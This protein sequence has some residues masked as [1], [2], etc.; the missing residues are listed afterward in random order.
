MLDRLERL[1]GSAFMV[2]NTLSWADVCVF[3]RLTQLL[4]MNETLL[5]GKWPKLRNVYE[6]VAALNSVRT[7][8]DA[9]ADDYPRGNALPP[10]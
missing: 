5:T 2:G 10:G 9:H 7:W 3:N 1:A 4:D 8:I 6:T